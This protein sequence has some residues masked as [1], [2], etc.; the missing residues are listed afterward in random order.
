MLATTTKHISG[1]VHQDKELRHECI[2]LRVMQVYF[3]AVSSSQRT[4]NTHQRKR[5]RDSD[6]VVCLVRCC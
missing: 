2:R 5:H 1:I 4:D 3:L 6:I